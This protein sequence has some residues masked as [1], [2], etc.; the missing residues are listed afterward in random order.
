[1]L[2]SDESEFES[3][4]SSSSSESDSEDYSDAAGS[5]SDA[6]APAD[7]AARTAAEVGLNAH[8][9]SEEEAGLLPAGASEAD[10][11]RVR[12]AV[13]CRWRADVSRVLTEEAALVA[14][15]EE[16]KPLALAA[17]RFLS[18]L[19]YINFGVAP[20]LHRRIADAPQT[21]GS[22]VV[23]GAGC[24]GLAAARQLRAAGYK[25]AVV[26]GRQRPG[27]RVWTERLEVRW[28]GGG[29]AL[30]WR[31]MP[32]SCR[33][34]GFANR[35][36]LGLHAPA[37]R[38]TS[39]PVLRFLLVAAGRPTPLSRTHS[40]HSAAPL[41]PATPQ[42]QGARAVADIG[43]S[44]ITGIDGNPLAVLVKQM[45]LH[46]ADIRSGGWHV[47]MRHVRLW[48]MHPWGCRQHA[49]PCQC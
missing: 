13:L 5:A 39:H 35:R 36:N 19:G 44:I 21:A 33:H 7:P 11:V 20:A 17:H 24:A 48:H 41:P 16:D 27:G 43:G 37:A 32:E 23:I 25:V 9:L 1:M 38:P 29:R 18:A 28:A 2:C 49:M 6:D 45:G 40:T 10:Y 34:L 4:C 12:N 3:S 14:V 30:T 8:G 26:E 22:V 42:A 46:M 47:H 31:G 15:A